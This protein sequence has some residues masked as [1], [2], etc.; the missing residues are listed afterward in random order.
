MEHNFLGRER[1]IER[2]GE[3]GRV[4]KWCNTKG[5]ENKRALATAD[6][7]CFFSLVFESQFNPKYTEN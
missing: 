5:S 7:F 4:K 1:Q 2:E 3:G 6:G